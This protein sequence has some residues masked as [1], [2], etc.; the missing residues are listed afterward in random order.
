MA[1]LVQMRVQAPDVERLV[2]TAKRFEPRFA[3]LGAREQSVF[4][5]AGDS[6]EVSVFAEWDSHDVMHA[7]TE[8]LGERF[9]EEAGTEGLTWETRIWRRR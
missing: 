8:Q 4:Q 1:V 3:E 6:G 5:V 9:N 7:A 2:A